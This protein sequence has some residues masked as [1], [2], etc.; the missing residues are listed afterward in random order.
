VTTT[1]LSVQHRTD[2]TLLS[3]GEPAGGTDG[4]LNERLRELELKQ[5]ALLA[6]VRLLEKGGENTMPRSGVWLLFLPL[7]AFLWWLV[8]RLG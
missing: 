1:D 6:R 5:D 2:P 8:Q 7:V 4:H 3:N